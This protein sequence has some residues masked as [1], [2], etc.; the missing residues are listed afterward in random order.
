MAIKFTETCIKD[1]VFS[2]LQDN[3]YIPSQRT[4]WA[5][6]S[7]KCKLLV[8]TLKFIT[9]TYCTHRAGTFYAP[10]KLSSFYKVPLC[11][12]RKNISKT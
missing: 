9:E 4:P 2:P 10:D 1:I 3:V 7:D 8:Q 11:H 5:S 6:K 12:A